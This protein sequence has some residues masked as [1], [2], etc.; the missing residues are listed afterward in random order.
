MLPEL[1]TAIARLEVTE[2]DIDYEKQ[3]PCDPRPAFDS[4]DTPPMW[5]AI[6]RCC[7]VT[8]FMCNEH[9]ERQVWLI[10]EWIKSTK[11]LHCTKCKYVFPLSEYPHDWLPL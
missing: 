4:C 5:R 6:N 2:L 8:T 10:T 7:G 3:V 1:H 11:R 9:K